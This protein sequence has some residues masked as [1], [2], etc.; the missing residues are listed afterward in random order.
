MHKPLLLLLLLL[1][2]FTGFS[3]SR[4][5]NLFQFNYV[6]SS[7]GGDGSILGFRYIGSVAVGE[8]LTAGAGVGHDIWIDNRIKTFNFSSVLAD[9]RYYFKGNE[10]GSNVFVTP[11]YAVKVFDSSTTGF[12]L[13]MGL[14][15]KIPLNDQ[16]KLMIGLGFD[17]HNIH[18]DRYR[19]TFQG[20]TFN[21]G[22]V[23]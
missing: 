8:R 3:Q 17:F 7:G 18:E 15:S 23:F 6:A 12:N 4:F 22:L 11:G 1:L 21:V 10:M 5:S 16:Q 13:N 20:V 19:Q 2:S 9:L 14:G